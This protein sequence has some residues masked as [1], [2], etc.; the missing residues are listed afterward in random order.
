MGLGRPSCPRSPSHNCG[1]RHKVAR[2][3]GVGLLP[4]PR[5]KPQVPTATTR[6]HRIA[7]ADIA[8][9]HPDSRQGQADRHEDAAQFP[10]STVPSPGPLSATA[11]WRSSR[12][13]VGPNAETDPLARRDVSRP[14][15]PSPDKDRNR[16]LNR[17]APWPRAPVPKAA[18][19]E[20]NCYTDPRRGHP[21]RPVATGKDCFGCWW[22]RC[23]PAPQQ[24][25][26]TANQ[27]SNRPICASIPHHPYQNS[28]NV[29]R[30]PGPILALYRL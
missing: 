27:T 28:E 11:R 19:A 12:F 16:T 30:K 8:R 3:C 10:A 7:G 22:K 14:T 21:E 25:E 9:R 29:R 2:L 24:K 17:P 6:R 18:E 4:D 5:Y 1:F 13:P 26:G 23:R 15:A 20:Q